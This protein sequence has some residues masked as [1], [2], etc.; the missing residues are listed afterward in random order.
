MPP[1]AA[2]LGR[3][4]L[5]G[6]V[7]LHFGPP[8]GGD[9]HLARL[10]ALEGADDAALLH[11]VDDARGARVAELEA[12]LEQGVI[13]E[14]QFAQTD[15]TAQELRLYLEKNFQEFRVSCGRRLEEIMV[16]GN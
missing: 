15:R 5:I 2:S 7:Q 13:T 1:G 9:E 14:C 4:L 6:A 10:A 11:L 16:Q 8:L 3:I 12:A